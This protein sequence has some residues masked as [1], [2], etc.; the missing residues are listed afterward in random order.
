MASAD[1]VHSTE[2][3]NPSFFAGLWK[4][5][6][7]KRRRNRARQL[8]YVRFRLTREGVHFVGILVFIFIGAV[9]REINLLILLAGA[10]IGLLLL[11][12][13]FN[14]S[15]LVGLQVRRS[16]P[17]TAAVGKPA[18]V[19]MQVL[20]PKYLLGAWLVMVQDRILKLSPR[21]RRSSESGTTLF[22]VVRPRGSAV[23]NYQLQFHERGLYEIGPTTLSTRFPLSLGIGWR[24]LTNSSE[25]IVHPAQGELTQAASKLFQMDQI[26]QA[27]SSAHAGTQEG[28]FFGLRPWATGDSKRWIHWRTT[29]RLGQLSVRQFERQQRRQLSVLLD[30][31]DDGTEAGREACE[32]AISFVATLAAV[33]VRH[34]RDRL[35]VGVAGASNQ[36]FTNVVSSI[37]VESL[38]DHL[39][40]AEASDAPN[41]LDA[42]RGISLPL[43]ANPN[44]L[45]VSPRRRPESWAQAGKAD[46]VM[47]RLLASLR[48]RWIDVS[49]GDLEPYFQWI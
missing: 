8:A 45:V 32:R 1:S 37:L 4:R 47:E 49:K 25:I 39:A 23:A 18:T 14:V 42:L 19:E 38:L 28:E 2:S 31:Y 12:W 44:L 5:W 6:Q 24:T 20:N 15:T 43:M 22:D 46:A 21:R 9:I 33:S 34:S 41:L 35:S 16:L 30:V 26:G 7:A 17:R 11:Q 13:R 48:V 36:S 29:A 27:K 40:V 10:M 3:K